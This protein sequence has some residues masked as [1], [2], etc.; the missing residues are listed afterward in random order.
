[1]QFNLVYIPFSPVPYQWTKR[2]TVVQSNV[3]SYW[4]EMNPTLYYI[5]NI[6]VMYRNT[7]TTYS[8]QWKLSSLLILCIWYHFVPM[9]CRNYYRFQFTGIWSRN[10]PFLGNRRELDKVMGTMLIHFNRSISVMNF[11]K[12]IAP[13]DPQGGLSPIAAVEVAAVKE[14]VDLSLEDE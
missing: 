3:L 8:K 9:D 2:I 11:K 4:N 10:R 13:S 7:M 5:P 12:K 6:K 14:V 1:M